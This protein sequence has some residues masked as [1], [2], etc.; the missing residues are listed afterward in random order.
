MTRWVQAHSILCACGRARLSCN[1]R[2]SMAETHGSR[3]DLATRL[4]CSARFAENS[5]RRLREGGHGTALRPAGEIEASSVQ[6]LPDRQVHVEI[7]V[8][9]ES[10]DEGDGRFLP[11]A[12]RSAPVVPSPSPAGWD[13]RACPWPAFTGELAVADRPVRPA[14]DHG[15]R[16]RSNLVKTAGKGRPPHD[17]QITGEARAKTQPPNGRIPRSEN[18]VVVYLPIHG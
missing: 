18:F 3:L 14:S 6:S 5:D 17:V 12:P 13:N 10:T 7:A 16:E 2:G 15:R 11:R 1:R 9:P 4:R 8:S